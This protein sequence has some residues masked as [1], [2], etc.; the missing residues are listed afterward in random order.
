[1]KIESISAFIYTNENAFALAAPDL[2]IGYV[3]LNDEIIDMSD[4]R[5]LWVSSDWIWASGYC[6]CSR[7]V[8]KGSVLKCKGTAMVKNSPYGYKDIDIEVII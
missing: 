8:P 2:S 6:N 4:Q 1:M 7:I 5:N 3:T